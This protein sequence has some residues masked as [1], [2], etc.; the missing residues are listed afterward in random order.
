MTDY[1]SS[2]YLPLQSYEPQPASE[3]SSGLKV[4]LA[5]CS[6]GYLV[7]EPDLDT[8]VE[9]TLSADLNVPGTAF[10]VPLS[11]WSV[12]CWKAVSLM[13]SGETVTVTLSGCSL[14]LICTVNL[15]LPLVTTLNV[16]EPTV[17][18]ARALAALTHVS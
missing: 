18:S 8:T 16:F 3:P 12:Q 11:D 7:V 6:S 2:S 9:D 17:T 1:S 14:T 13:S 15:P 5:E 10:F 4:I